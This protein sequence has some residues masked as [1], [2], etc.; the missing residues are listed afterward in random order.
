MTSGG[1]E[2][3]EWSEFGFQPAAKI[4]EF[5]A[6]ELAGADLCSCEHF[7]REHF[8]D[9]CAHWISEVSPTAIRRQCGCT[10][11]SAASAVTTAEEG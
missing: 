9:R 3:R 6:Q 11:F 7:R 1:V 5:R 4:R 2:P 8:P 10:G